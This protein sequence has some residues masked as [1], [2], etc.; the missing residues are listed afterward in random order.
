M[1]SAAVVHPPR[2]CFVT[3][4][5]ALG[6]VPVEPSRQFRPPHDAGRWPNDE[7][8]AI[9]VSR[10]S[11]GPQRPIE[12]AGRVIWQLFADRDHVPVGGAQVALRSAV[13]GLV[14]RVTRTDREGIFRFESVRTDLYAVLEVGPPDYSASAITFSTNRISI[15]NWIGPV[16]RIVLNVNVGCTGIVVVRADSPTLVSSDAL[17]PIEIARLGR[18][19]IELPAGGLETFEGVAHLGPTRVDVVPFPSAA[20]GQAFGWDGFLGVPRSMVGRTSELATVTLATLGQAEFRL[21]DPATGW[22]LRIRTGATARIRFDLAREPRAEEGFGAWSLPSFIR[23]GGSGA[24][25]E[26]TALALIDA[27]WREETGARFSVDSERRVPVMDVDVSHLSWWNCDRRRAP[28]TLSRGFVHAPRGIDV[29]SLWVYDHIPTVGASDW[30]RTAADGSFVT[31]ALLGARSLLRV[32]SV[33]DR[34]QVLTGGAEVVV[35]SSASDGG[36]LGDLGVVTV[37][38]ARSTCVRGRLFTNVTDWA[39]GT[40]REPVQGEVA[41]GWTVVGPSQW[42]VAAPDGSYCADVVPGDP[43]SVV[44]EARDECTR[45]GVLPAVRDEDANCESARERCVNV[46]AE[47]SCAGASGG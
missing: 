30:T 8:Y 33:S 32:R 40:R 36:V 2:W 43:Y 21:T 11:D 18:A 16:Q 4:A 6:C 45:V 17:C 13:R 35:T 29:G 3:L 37:R 39:R 34:L 26:T 38:Q 27:V 47:L 1:D 46:D 20:S 44:R 23:A 12:I 15:G 5:L 9:D 28:P 14:D 24:Q 7:V 42:I 19:S 31:G 10:A 22:P 41:L 25:D